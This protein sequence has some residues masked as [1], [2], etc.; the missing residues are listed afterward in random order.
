MTV[1]TAEDVEGLAAMGNENFNS[2][3]LANLNPRDYI[4]PNGS[5][6]TKLKEFIRMKYIDKRWHRDGRGGGGGGGSGSGGGFATDFH[7]SGSTGGGGAQPDNSNKI[8]L[9]LNTGTRSVRVFSLIHLIPPLTFFV[10]RLLCQEEHRQEP[11]KSRRRRV[12]VT[13][14]SQETSIS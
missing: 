9:K 2:I 7:S 5:D 4:V 1:F 8:A 11:L 3:Y 12:L 13:T 14:P 6:L 10:Y